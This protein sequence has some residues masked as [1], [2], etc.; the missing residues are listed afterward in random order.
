MRRSFTQEEHRSANREPPAR[1]V[2]PVAS[3]EGAAPAV[4]DL[5]T[6]VANMAAVALRHA[7]SV[8]AAA[9]FPSEAFESAKAE[10]L[11]GIQVPS[12]LGGEGA[13]VSART[14]F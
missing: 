9:R 6:R 13:T 3:S 7:T 1:P 2:A 11:L 4:A 10:R 14:K 5:K 8:D 12:A